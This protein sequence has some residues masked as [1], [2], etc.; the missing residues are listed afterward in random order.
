MSFWNRF[1]ETI[2]G[3]ENR[4]ARSQ[5]VSHDASRYGF[6]DIE[7]GIKDRKIHDIGALRWDGAVYHSANRQELM[8]FLKDVDFVCGH[9]IINHD[10]RYLFGEKTHRCLLVDTLFLSPLLFPERPYHRLLKDD[11][12]ISEQIGRSSK[13]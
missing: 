11:K 5:E 12:L 9:N 1:I 8:N 2:N 4:S 10:A 6:V 7:V 3:V 13:K